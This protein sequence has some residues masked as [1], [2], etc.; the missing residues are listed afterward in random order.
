MYFVGVTTGGS[1]I[2]RVFSVWKPLL[3][4][5][6]VEL[7]GINV[8]VRASTQQYRRVVEHLRN[9]PLSRGALV[10]THKI[11]LFAACRDL[12]VYIDDEAARLGETSALVAGEEG[13]GARALDKVTSLLALE[14]LVPSISGRELL[15]MGAG[16]AALALGD[17]LAH[18][19]GEA[20]S[21]VTVTDLSPERLHTFARVTT[22]GRPDIT[23]TLTTLKSGTTHDAI[24]A[25]L[26]PHAVVVNATG[27]GKDRPGSPVT[28]TAEFPDDGVVWDFNY[29]G[30]L[31]LLA[32]A[33]AQQ[34]RHRLV[35]EDG[36]RY[37]VHGWIQA[38]GAVFS[39][40]APRSGATFEA[41]FDASQAVR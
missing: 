23:W 16:G 31:E 1:A 39:V 17:A 8:P 20:P 22:D 12:F 18:S 3:G 26:P 28:D 40:G 7:V 29:R 10:T 27:M 37:F 41:L 4:L 6:D 14:S 35:V 9:D 11:N 2:H 25:I 24:L 15:V 5:D 30:S 13:V 33:R 32:Q 19:S 34:S 21:A 36:W 38:I